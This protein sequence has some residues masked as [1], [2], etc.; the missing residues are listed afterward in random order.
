MIACA[1]L[2][3]GCAGILGWDDGTEPGNTT[4]HPLSC[5]EKCAISFPN[6]IGNESNG[7]CSCACMPGFI[8]HEGSCMSSELY[9]KLK[10]GICD[11]SCREEFPNTKGRI[12]AGNCTC[13]CLKDFAYYNQSCIPAS[14]FREKFADVCSADHPVLKFYSWSYGDIDS[15]IYLCFERQAEYLDSNRDGRSDYWNFVND[16]RSNSSVT[17]VTKLLENISDGENL[18]GYEKA[19]FAIAFVQ[20]LPYTYDNVSTPYDDYPRFPS[21]TIY[22]DG[23]DCEDT[24]ILMAS[25]LKQMGYDV[26]LLLL[27]RHMA[28][29]VACDPANFSY[30]VSSYHYEGSDYCYLE[31]TGENFRLGEYPPDFTA[32]A[33]ATVIPVPSGLAPD[34]YISNGIRFASSS[35]DSRYTY[36]DVSGVHIDNYGTAVA[37]GVS[38]YT[39]LEPA[40]GGGELSGYTYSAGDIPAAGYYDYNLTHLRVKTGEQFR[41]LVQVSGSN[42]DTVTSR[43]GW[44]EWH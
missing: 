2:I 25:I 43:T 12:K 23:G 38:I 30:P 6:T 20:G 10:P 14:E 29:G 37:K 8:W 18:S 41:V 33:N 24:S 22:A 32:G 13:P 44:A 1:L 3:P 16:P 5:D 26:V 35:H 28:V 27:P 9:D 36:V 42:F 17:L 11:A 7:N 15:Y 40:G 21:E 19:E 34:I 4:P 39:A 31:T